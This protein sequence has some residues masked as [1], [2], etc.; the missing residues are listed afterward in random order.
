MRDETGQARDQVSDLSWCPQLGSLKIQVYGHRSKLV[1][2]I[3]LLVQHCEF[4]LHRLPSRVPRLP[5]CRRYVATVVSAY[6]LDPLYPVAAC[7][8]FVIKQL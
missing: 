8:F 4:W 3:P 7:R 5:G 2:L 6:T 1:S